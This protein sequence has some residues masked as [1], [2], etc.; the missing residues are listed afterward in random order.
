MN[1]KLFDEFRL[2]ANYW[3][4]HRGVK[5]W[6]DWHP[7]EI[8]VE[9][10]EMKSIGINTARIFLTWNDFQPIKE[11]RGGH[12]LGEP[13]KICLRHDENQTIKN[14]PEL[15]DYRMIE[16]FDELVRI[17]KKYQIKIIPALIVGWMGGNCLDIDFRNG[18]N[19]FTDPTMLHYQVLYFRYFAKRYKDEDTILGWEFGNETECFQ[20]CAT[21]DAQWNW[22]N[23]LAS[24]L[25]LY[26][27]KHPIIP[28]TSGFTISK[29]KINTGVFYLPSV[30][31]ICDCTTSHTYMVFCQEAIDEPLS[32][33][34]TYLPSWRSRL[35]AGVG[36]K[37]AM[38]E[39]ISTIGTS[40][41]SDETSVLYLRTVLYSLLA[42]ED[43]GF[44][45]WTHSDFT[46][47]DMVPYST[48]STNANKE[49]GMGLFTAYGRPKPQAKEMLS[50]SKVLKKID[51]KQMR[52]RP[53]QTAVVLSPEGVW[54]RQE[55]RGIGYTAY[56][57]SK[58]AGMDADIISSEQDFDKYKLLIF[59]S[60]NGTPV[61][62]KYEDQRRI[63]KFV[64][65]GGS[66]YLSI[67]NGNW[68]KFQKMFG[69]K[70]VN[71]KM[72]TR[73][74]I[75]IRFNK[76]WGELRAGRELIYETG[77][78]WKTYGN[79]IGCKVVATLEGNDM[80]ALVI[81]NYGSGKIILSMYPIEYLLSSLPDVLDNDDT[82][83]IYKN[84]KKISG[85]DTGVEVNNPFLEAVLFDSGKG[86]YLI[87]V[88]HS[89]KN[90]T[91]KITL[92]EKVK[93][94]VDLNTS[95]KLEV[96]KEDGCWINL[97]LPGNSG[98]VVELS[99]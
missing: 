86:K 34:G 11:F 25:R 16:R 50:F 59:P 7:E 58:M 62:L 9:F 88:N 24:T 3:P 13:A 66:L 14:N 56:V 71:K 43:L 97:S 39:E 1:N 2:G 85:I 41:M 81:N 73:G 77:K 22:M 74:E 8:E 60:I 95:K 70:V 23:T 91:E 78:C 61:A 19:I 46:T 17:A 92:S 45:W 57:L 31:E 6:Q 38:T 26:D 52:K 63:E 83:L 80:P 30:A 65:N 12:N 55:R 5:M 49:E 76:D 21:V 44:L 27:K 54:D 35:C 96:R 51:Y 28:G 18:R 75:K 37:P 93:E 68:E 90:I 33:K 89:K 4:R 40:Y 15:M 10:K 53:A 94:A 98:K 64:K 72:I 99:T 47:T 42:N 29:R 69:L 67:Y 20:P 84:L 36:G 87:V 32:L 82:Y 48:Y 79:S